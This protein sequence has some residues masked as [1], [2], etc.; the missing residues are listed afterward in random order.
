MIRTLIERLHAGP[1]RTG[2]AL[3]VA[4]LA[5]VHGTIYLIGN[6]G[7]AAICSHIAADMLKN[8]LHP[9]TLHD[10]P[11]LSMLANDGEWEDVFLEQLNQI[12]EKDM[13]IAISSSG[14][15]ENIVKAAQH[16]RIQD[17]ALV[18]FSGFGA[19]NRLRGLGHTNYWCNSNNYGVVEICHLAWL[20]EIVNPG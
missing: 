10:S 2:E 9:R 17:A 12:G 18:T 13:L 5:K 1:E 19:Y 15:S 4:N 7:S 3:T 8:G 16:A 14:Q 6:G 11:S 20:H